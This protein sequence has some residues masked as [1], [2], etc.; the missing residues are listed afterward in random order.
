LVNRKA[1]MTGQAEMGSDGAGELPPAP[2]P[3]VPVPLPPVAAVLPPRRRCWS[4]PS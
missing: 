4:S 1:G 2:L 3:P